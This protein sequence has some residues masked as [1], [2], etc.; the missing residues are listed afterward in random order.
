[1]Q[2]LAEKEDVGNGAWLLGY[3]PNATSPRDAFYYVNSVTQEERSGQAM[4]LRL[5]RS[6][7]WPA[8]GGVL[9]ASSL[10]PGQHGAGCA[11]CS[12]GKDWLGQQK[13]SA[14]SKAIAGRGDLK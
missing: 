5:L 3:Q 2:L 4:L 9:A 7:P 6:Q 12:G 14:E 13:V 10:L 8:V 11:S 1:M